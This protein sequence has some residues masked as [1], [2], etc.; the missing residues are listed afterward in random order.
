MRYIALLRG[1]NVGGKNKVDMKTLVDIMESSGFKEVSTYINSGNIFFA[2][3]A[4][5]EDLSEA[6]NRLIN[7]EFDIDV[8][9][10]VK[11]RPSIERIV[12]DIPKDWVNGEEYKCDVMFLWPKYDAASVIDQLTI[13]SVDSVRYVSGALIWKVDRQSIGRSG[14][15]KIVGTDLYANITVRNSNTA[16]A[17][18]ERL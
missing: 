11:D 14:M 12:N 1:I 17:I 9:V 16:R 3:D 13:K 10:L 8:P 18:A 15:N 2:S 4:S 5:V 6:I 7:K